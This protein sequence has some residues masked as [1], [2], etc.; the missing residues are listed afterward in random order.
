MTTQKV[1]KTSITQRLRT[2]LGRSVG[3]TT[4]TKM[5]WIN[6]LRDPYL[7]TNLTKLYNQNDKQISMVIEWMLMYVTEKNKTGLPI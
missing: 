4:A 6:R 7:S 2:D 3:V 1:T 5:V